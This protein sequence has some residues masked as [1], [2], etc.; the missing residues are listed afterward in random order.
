MLQS[1][2]HNRPGSVFGENKSVPF[3]HKY[4]KFAKKMLSDCLYQVL[5]VGAPK[6]DQYIS[7]QGL[8]NFKVRFRTIS[9]IM[10]KRF[11]DSRLGEVMINFE[12]LSKCFQQA[13]YRI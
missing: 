4:Y 9:E 7:E 3:L 5:L 6:E 8:H 1:L 12:K 11:N 10:S 2:L 13:K